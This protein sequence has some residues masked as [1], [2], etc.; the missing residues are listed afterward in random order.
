MIKAR[1]F[2]ILAGILFAINACMVWTG[3][4]GI[5]GGPLIVG[6]LFFAMLICG[7]AVIIG[8]GLAKRK[9]AKSADPARE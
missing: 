5:Y 6:V 2:F 1:V 3:E 4:P 7:I 9:R 8:D